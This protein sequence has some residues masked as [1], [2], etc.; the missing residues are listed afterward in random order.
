MWFS[1]WHLFL[2]GARFLGSVPWIIYRLNVHMQT[3]I[4]EYYFQL[5]HQ[6]VFLVVQSFILICDAYRK[7]RG[8]K[9]KGV[10]TLFYSGLFPW[11]L[12]R[13]LSDCKV[14]KK[15]PN[16][17]SLVSFRW[18]QNMYHYKTYSTVSGSLY[19]AN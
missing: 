8:T 15:S 3:I 1:N 14:H 19:N 2:S 4:H 16:D 13:T 7:G 10:D 6:E 18:I 11:Y 9:M 17:Y 12:E 5:F